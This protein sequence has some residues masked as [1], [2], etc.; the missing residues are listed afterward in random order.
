M[1]VFLGG[2]CQGVDWRKDLEKVLD[3][4]EVDYFDPFIRDRKRT[5]QDRRRE[6]KERERCD[7][8][9]YVITT[10]IRGVYSIAEVVDDSNKKPDSTLFFFE[11]EGNGITYP[12]E[13]IENSLKEVGKMVERNG[14]KWFKTYKE[15]EEFFKSY[16]KKS[17]KA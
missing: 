4:S 8:T 17:I 13:G 5:E 14:G 3:K 12:L 2:T 16:N 15:M 6:I 1:R 7:Y 9:L 11:S 10:D